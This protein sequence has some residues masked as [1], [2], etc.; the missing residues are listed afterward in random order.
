MGEYREYKFTGNVLVNGLVNDRNFK[1]ETAAR[2]KREAKRNIIYQYKDLIGLPVVANVRLDGK[3][4]EKKI[5]TFH[6]TV[7]IQGKLIEPH[8]NFRCEAYCKE[9]MW[10]LMKARYVSKNFLSPDAE[11]I[12]KGVTDE[13]SIS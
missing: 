1:A 8:F 13:Q 4:I 12:F 6:G 7:E 3:I 9:D 11:V 2:S 10:N 5:Y